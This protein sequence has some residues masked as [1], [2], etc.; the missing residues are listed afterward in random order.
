M[1]RFRVHEGDGNGHGMETVSLF[2]EPGDRGLAVPSDPALDSAVPFFPESARVHLLNRLLYLLEYSDQILLVAGPAGSG[3]TTL[4]RQLDAQAGRSWQLCRLTAEQ[5]FGA[6]ELLQQIAAGFGAAELRDA[7]AVLQ[8]RLVEHLQRLLRQGLNPVVVIDA[9]E[10]LAPSA[11]ADVL[12][13]SRRAVADT[14][15][16]LHVLLAGEATSEIALA[17]AS[18]AVD[19][20]IYRRFDMSPFAEEDLADYV[21]HVLRAWGREDRGADIAVQLSRL[22]RRTG[23]WPG[24]VDE[25][26][27]QLLETRED[28][29]ANMFTAWLSRLARRGAGLRVSGRMRSLGWVLLALGLLAVLGLQREINTIVESADEQAD[30]VAEGGQ[31]IALD[32]PPPQGSTAIASVTEAA[33]ASQAAGT[34]EG[35][36]S[37][38]AV[39]S[40]AEETTEPPVL[41]PAEEPAPQ[42]IAAPAPAAEI[43]APPRPA[44]KAPEP[45]KSVPIIAGIQRESWLLEQKSSDYTLQ[46]MSVRR[47][48]SLVDFIRRHPESRR[49][50]YYRVRRGDTDW[51]NLVYEIYPDTASAQQ[52][53][54]Q[55]PPDLAKLGPMVRSLGTVKSDIQAAAR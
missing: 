37:A 33:D 19:G 31:S 5:R 46:L 27:R 53:R 11:L 41:A 36:P 1:N 8:G 18:A 4:L 34:G 38:V 45:S 22:Q 23:G 15:R 26:L 50:A 52:A 24:R 42:A 30:E 2:A 28:T 49:L 48:S 55:L 9:A 25:A 43:K 7:G 54:A 32:V 21:A 16:R 20:I 39:P 3:K 29:G 17:E 35:E 51:Y 44:V 14:G 13:L 10:R 40:A 47:E 6:D 12:D